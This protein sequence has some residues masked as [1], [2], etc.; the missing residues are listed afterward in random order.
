MKLSFWFAV[1]LV[2]LACSTAADVVSLPDQIADTD[3][4]VT[5]IDGR[6]VFEVQDV[7]DKDLEFVPSDGQGVDAFNPEECQPGEG[8]FLDKCLGNSDC[9]SGWCVNHLGEG[10]CSKSCQEDCPA[11]WT[12]S[13]VGTGPDI[14]YICVSDHANLCRPCTDSDD[15]QGPGGTE[16]SCVDY[17]SG[18]GFCGGHCNPLNKVSA[19]PEGFACQAGVTTEGIETA[20]CV[21]AAGLCPCSKKAVTLGLWTGCLVQNE[22]GECSGKM[23]CEEAGLSE[24]DAAVPGEEACNGIDDNCDGQVDEATCDD[25]NACTTDSCTGEGGCLFEPLTGANCDDSDA[26]TITDHCDEGT[27]VG[28]LIACND[29]NPCTDDSCDGLSGCLFET[30]HATCDDGNACTVGDSCLDGDCAGTSVGCECETDQDCAAYEDANACNGTLICVQKGVQF[31]CVIDPLTVVECSPPTGKNANCLAAKCKAVDGSCETVPAN[32]S[33][34]C[35]DGNK[36][37]FGETCLDGLCQ[38]MSPLNCNDGDPCTG[39]ACHPEEGCVHEFNSAPCDDDN[40]CTFADFCQG[41]ECLPGEPFDCDDANLCTDDICNPLKGCLHTN[42]TQACDDQDPCTLQDKCSGGS[43]VGTAPKDCDDDNLCTDDLCIPLAGCSHENN[44]NLCDDGDKCSVGDSC[45]AGS[46]ISGE[47]LSCNDGNP[48]TEDLCDPGLGCYHNS[49]LSDCNDFNPCTTDDQCSNGKCIGTGSIDCD[50]AKPCTK[51]IC[52]PDGGCQHENIDIAC[53]DGNPCTLNDWC[54]DGACQPGL[55]FDCNDGEPCTDDVCNDQ[56]A[57][58]HTPND[59]DCDDGNPCTAGD[60]CAAGAC[61]PDLMT[62]CEDDNVCTTDSCHP[63]DGCIHALNTVACDDGDPCTAGDKCALGICG[64]GATVD[65]ADANPCTVDSCVDGKCSHAPQDGAC[66]DNNPCT[67]NDICSAGLCVGTSLTV[68]E[69][70]NV[71]TDDYCLPLQG[72]QHDPIA[73][74]CSDEDACTLDDQCQAGACVGGAEPNCDDS[75]VCT[76][77][78]C[79]SNLGCIHAHDDGAD[80][81]DSNACTQTDKCNAGSCVGSNPL[82]CDDGNVCTTDTC[83]TGQGCLHTN[84]NGKSCDDG[85]PATSNDLC[86]D[87]VCKGTTGGSCG[88]KLSKD[89]QQVKA[90]WTLCYVPQNPPANIANAACSTL[91]SSA[92]KTYGCWHGHSTYP[93]QDNNNM[94]ANACKSGVQHSTK[95]SSWGGSDHILT[96]CIKN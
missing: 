9:L 67:E 73:G 81:D 12:C 92:G 45:V 41:G 77:D 26:C 68:C 86:Q 19:C 63:V 29:N 83:D 47:T 38:G 87:G 72:C 75:N 6:T 39:D 58:V 49:N 15:C 59:G 65:C 22:W 18:M 11:G 79:D 96:V 48:C 70:D 20:Q 78:S 2:S 54:K 31:E 82:G 90:G 30:N 7:N 16:D 34:A 10:V 8:C 55:E 60:H 62:D 93:H 28:S 17:G 57:C 24:C 33:F 71:C 56:G 50:D 13:Q 42:N 80:C 52:L 74:S 36:C 88:P 32:N 27:C 94:I 25:D 35:E 23:V 21:A 69:D 37:T 61:K 91:F 4:D 95:Y 44:G 51:D 76:T 64:A 3:G 14:V 85:N 84:D 5:T 46:C 1:V 89:P 40:M 53:T 43:C 66:D